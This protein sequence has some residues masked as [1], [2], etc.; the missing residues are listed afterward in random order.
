MVNMIARKLRI[1]NRHLGNDNRRLMM[2]GRLE[3]SVEERDEDHTHM[4]FLSRRGVRGEDHTYMYSLQQR[5]E[6]EAMSGVLAYVVPQESH[7]ER[8][9]FKVYRHKKQQSITAQLDHIIEFTRYRFDPTDDRET[10]CIESAFGKNTERKHTMYAIMNLDSA[11]V[12]DRTCH[13]NDSNM[14][15]IKDWKSAD[16]IGKMVAALQ[17]GEEIVTTELQIGKAGKAT[18]VVTRMFQLPSNGFTW[19]V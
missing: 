15:V 5:K 9:R 6:D 16:G 7:P 8:V 3:E 17:R 13:S 12:I 1:W 4:V 14:G 19:T 2:G 11:C 18:L 10:V